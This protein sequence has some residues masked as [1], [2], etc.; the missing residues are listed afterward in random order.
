MIRFT[1][2]ISIGLFT[3]HFVLQAIVSSLNQGLPSSPS[4]HISSQVI[5][6]RKWTRQKQ[7]IK[8]KS[9]QITRQGM[10]LPVGGSLGLEWVFSHQPSPEC[11]AASL[12]GC[13]S[14]HPR[15]SLFHVR[16]VDSRAP[17]HS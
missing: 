15:A 10:G 3:L 12:K 9:D 13:S 1:R 8:K 17:Y 6:L 4:V 11:L 14:R 7:D 5:F 2:S 16:K